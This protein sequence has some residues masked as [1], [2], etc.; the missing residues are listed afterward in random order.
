[1]VLL[2]GALAVV[3]SITAINGLPFSHPYRVDAIVPGSGPI[4]R[5]GDEVRVAGRRVGEVRE[6][7]PAPGGRRV[8]MEL[9]EGEVGPGATATVRLR[10][11]AGAVFVELDPGDAAA[12][13]PDGATIPRPDTASGVQLTDV[14]EGFDT[15][16]R[17]ALR[18]AATGYGAGIAGRGP[19][20]NRALA[21]LPP[22]LEGVTPLLRALDPRPGAL[23]ALVADAGTVT[24]ALGAG[25]PALAELITASRELFEATASERRALG[26]SIEAAPGAQSELAKLTP[27]AAPLLDDLVTTSRQLTPAAQE[28]ERAL[29]AVNGVLDRGPELGGLARLAAQASPLLDAA[30]PLP[31]AYEP[32]ALTL[33]PLVDAGEPLAEY[34]GRYRDEIFNG[35]YGF[36]TWGGFT[37]EQGEA[38]GAK[39]VRFAPVFTCAPGRDPYPAPGEAANDRQP[40]NG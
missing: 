28:L 15:N 29:P 22:V 17:T 32:A 21:D 20:L 10:G 37:Y 33:A 8:T 2:V 23:S 25:A 14:I 4:V 35:P 18:R 13:D 27:R 19:E 26:D 3:I 31:A 34:A 40:C 6:V 12:A 36:T 11:L 24:G 30:D 38:S 16:T 39:A 1:V 7:E 9:S 5:P